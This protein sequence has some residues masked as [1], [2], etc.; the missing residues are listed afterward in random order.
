VILRITAHALRSANHRTG[1][2]KALKIGLRPKWITATG[3]LPHC[4]VMRTPRRATLTKIYLFLLVLRKNGSVFGACT[5]I[6]PKLCRNIRGWPSGPEE[7]TRSTKRR[8]SHFLVP[9][10]AFVSI[11]D[12]RSARFSTSPALLLSSQYWPIPRMSRGVINS[13]K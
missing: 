5:P 4:S 3:I 11:R 1:A 8:R 9:T 6:N 10:S 12:I 13:V 7:K 2:V